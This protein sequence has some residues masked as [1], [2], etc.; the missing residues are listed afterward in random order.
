M[1]GYDTYLAQVAEV[2]VQGNQLKVH[3]HRLRDRL[4]ADGESRH[5]R[6]RRPKA[7][8]SSASPRR[9][10]ARSTSRTGS[11]K[12]QN[13]DDYRLLRMNEMPQIE[14]HSARQHGEAG[15]HGRAGRR[16]SWRLRSATRST[17]RRASGSGRCRSRSRDSSV[18]VG[19]SAAARDAVHLRCCSRRVELPRGSAARAPACAAL[20]M[21]EIAARTHRR[22]ASRAKRIV[23]QRSAEV[24]CFMWLRLRGDATAGA[25]ELGGTG[26]ATHD[27]PADAQHVGD[28]DPED[29]RQQHRERGVEPLIEDQLRRDRRLFR[30]AARRRRACP[31]VARRRR[32]SRCAASARTIFCHAA[33]VV[34]IASHASGTRGDPRVAQLALLHEDAGRDAQRDAGEQLVRDAEQRPEDVDAAVR[35]DDADVQEVAPAGDDESRSTAART[36]TTTSRRAAS[37]RGPA[38]PAA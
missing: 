24:A 1:S 17:R 8:S 30:T 23:A 9:C 13:F 28:H 25:S 33:V 15:R 31:R 34:T 20:M 2:S 19:D 35:I 14:V 38:R 26:Q 7:A 12:E 18:D 3:S 5:R 36:D 4:R 6:R 16:R 11:V 22:V 32:G 10:G 29:R 27:A 37:I 21:R